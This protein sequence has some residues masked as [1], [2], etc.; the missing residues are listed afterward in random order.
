[1]N[2]LN[3]SLVFLPSSLSF[4]LG[5]NGW[6]WNVAPTR[7]AAAAVGTSWADCAAAVVA[8]A[9]CDVGILVNTGPMPSGDRGAGDEGGHE[10]DEG[11][12]EDDARDSQDDGVAVAGVDG[13]LRCRCHP[14]VSNPPPQGAEGSSAFLSAA[15]C[16]TT[17]AQP[18]SPAGDC[19]L[20]M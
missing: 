16:R 5:T 1:M 8:A 18:P 2:S 12:S 20:M 19:L 13:L 10:R 6:A 14:E 17:P 4:F 15:G 3:F 11:V 7:S 9:D